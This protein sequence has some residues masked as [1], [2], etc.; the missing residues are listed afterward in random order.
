MSVNLFM[1]FM[2][3]HCMHVS[4]RQACVEL[5]E[6]MPLTPMEKLYCTGA[7]ERRL[8]FIVPFL[9]HNLPPRGPDTRSHVPD[10]RHPH[11]PHDTPP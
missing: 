9:P 1:H 4:D 7:L 11:G 3:L 6:A 2:Q 10:A 8:Q 5:L